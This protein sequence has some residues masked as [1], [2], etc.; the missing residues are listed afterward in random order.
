[1][2]RLLQ[3]ATM[4]AARHSGADW[5]TTGIRPTDDRVRVVVADEGRGGAP[6]RPGDYGLA[7]MRRRALA[8]GARLAIVSDP[9]GIR[10]I[11]DLPRPAASQ[12]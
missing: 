7:N 10:I 2:F 4:N 9:D 8:I 11:L 3:E 5:G 1:M 6:D 12:P